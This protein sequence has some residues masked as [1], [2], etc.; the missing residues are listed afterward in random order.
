MVFPRMVDGERFDKFANWKMTRWG[1]VVAKH[2]PAVHRWVFDKFFSWIVKKSWGTLDPQ[3]RLD[4]TPFYATT[5]SGM[6]VNDDLIPALLAGRVTSTVGVK[7]VLGPRS[8]ELDDGT[9]LQD[10]DAIIACTGYRNT[11]RVL[12]GIITYSKPRPEL[13]FI[14]DL[15]HGIFALGFED[16]IACLNYAIV[17]DTAATC[18]EIS[19][20]AVAQVWAGKSSLPPR[21]DMEL[22][23]QRDNLWFVERCLETELPIYEGVREPSEWLRFVNDMAGTGVYEYLGWT[24]KGIRFWL[25]EPSMY[26]LMAWGVNSPH[27][28]RV[29][30]TG[31][32]MAWPGAREAIRDINRLSEIDLS[33]KVKST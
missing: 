5:I 4:R 2:F 7:Q 32:R 24:W 19:A 15:Y 20:M 25:S 8:V 6:V 14:P 3:W 30:E 28:Y 18:R 23:I 13:P 21:A 27:M 31:K 17:M 26:K 12:D 22:Q 16:S 1:F 9:I 11:L 29:F 10:V 33:V